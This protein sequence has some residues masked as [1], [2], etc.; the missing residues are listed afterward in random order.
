MS[1]RLNAPPCNALLVECRSLGTDHFVGTVEFDE[2]GGAD[3][4][5]ELTFADRVTDLLINGKPVETTPG[6]DGTRLTLQPEMKIGRMTVEFSCPPAVTLP[7]LW[8]RGRFRVHSS[9]GFQRTGGL[10]TTGGPFVVTAEQSALEPDLVSDGFP[11]AFETLTVA[12]TFGTDRDLEVLGFDDLEADAMRVRMGSFD[13]GWLWHPEDL[14]AIQVNQPAGQHVLH[15]DLVPNGYNHYGPHHYY[16][17]DS[18]VVGPAQMRG[19]KNFADPDDAPSHTHVQLW[20]FRPFAVPR[21]V[22]LV[23]AK[24]LAEQFTAM[25]DTPLP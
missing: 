2:F 13:S 23:E 20:N 24:D 16:R 11:F 9:S 3:P 4:G 25:V 5:I 18:V 6:E 15:L 7:F 22:W 12:A 21:T 17:G 8:L 14:V 1:W 10:L 19:E